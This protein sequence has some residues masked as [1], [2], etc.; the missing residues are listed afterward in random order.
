MSKAKAVSSP[1]PKNKT[2]VAAAKDAKKSTA[3]PVVKAT[4]KTPASVSVKAT[5]KTPA[6]AVAKKSVE[7][8]AAANPALSIASKVPAEVKT[9]GASLTLDG[10][11]YFLANFSNEAKLHLELVRFA[12]AELKRL[13]RQT[14]I[15]KTALSFHKNALI[16][17]LPAAA[18]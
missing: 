5:P 10:K 1:A 8:V 18:E 2:S 6:T 3:K 15:T 7:K 9:S 17:T 11:K 12:D 14:A 4:T 16:A 13:N